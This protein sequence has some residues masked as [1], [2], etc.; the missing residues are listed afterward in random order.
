MISGLFGG[1]GIF[2]LGMILLTDGLKNLAGE[3]LKQGLKKLTGGVSSSI[4]SGFFMTAILQSSHA[5]ILT[6]IGFVSAGLLTFQQSIGLILGANL[7]TTSTGWIV[8][9]IGFKMSMGKIVFP[10]IGIGALLK[11]LSKG[12][13]GEIGITIAGFSLLFLGIEFLQTSMKEVATV[14][15]PSSIASDG[16]L[17]KVY[18]VLSGLGMTIVMQSSSAALAT[19]LSALNEGA[20]NVKQACYMVIGQ[21]IGTTLTAGIAAVGASVSAKRTATIHIVFN[22]VAAVVAFLILEPLLL[23]LGILLD[24]LNLKDPVSNIAIFHTAFNLLGIIIFLP[25]TNRF[26]E[27]VCRILPEKEN[28][29]NKYLDKVLYNSPTLALDTVERG[30]FEIFKKSILVLSELLNGSL[31]TENLKMQTDILRN[32]LTESLNFTEKIPHS[33]ISI[34]DQENHTSVLHCID[35]IYNLLSAIDE[36][37]EHAHSIQSDTTGRMSLKLSS[38]LERLIPL[39]DEF[40]LEKLPVDS[41]GDESGEMAEFRKKERLRILSE[42][43][44]GKIKPSSLLLD[45]DTIRWFDRVYYYIWRTSYHFQH[46]KN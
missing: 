27:L 32:E 44:D 35:H 43:V 5:T 26:S 29:S 36:G 20:L 9:L 1:I 41:L 38:T 45:I 39:L 22:V 4:G 12:K 2:I 21:N 15:N 13:L 31:S 19:T 3:S 8:S 28:S 40:Q 18:L 34:Q 7:G 23:G 11:L 24:W 37:I 10:L 14:F 25:F 30:V 46:R 16:I 6:T 33:G 17:D 42:A